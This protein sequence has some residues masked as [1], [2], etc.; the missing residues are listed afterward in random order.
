MVE[1]IIANLNSSKVSGPD[2][3]PVVILKNYEP[4]LS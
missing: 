3:I 4:E 2:W 1:K